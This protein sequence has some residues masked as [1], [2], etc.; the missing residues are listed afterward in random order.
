MSI[1]L[2]DYDEIGI[3]RLLKEI[4]TIIRILVF[5][6]IKAGDTYEDR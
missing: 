6:N 5:I 4:F 3:C 1:Y 2:A